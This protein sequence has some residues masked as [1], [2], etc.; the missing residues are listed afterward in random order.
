[1][2]AELVWAL[3]SAYRH[4]MPVVALGSATNAANAEFM[5]EERDTVW[6]ARHDF[7]TGGA[8]F[9]DHPIIH[10]NNARGRTQT[11]SFD[12]SVAG[13]HHLALVR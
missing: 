10:R 7:E 6:S 3:R 9:A 13:G 5:V 2:L 11:D 8:D 1:M 4:G 12:R